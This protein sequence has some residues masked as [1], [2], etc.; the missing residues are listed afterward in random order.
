MRG[1]WQGNF[2]DISGKST[3]NDEICDSRGGD[4]KEKAQNP[5]SLYLLTF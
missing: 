5:L 1:I 2:Y 4:T 3:R